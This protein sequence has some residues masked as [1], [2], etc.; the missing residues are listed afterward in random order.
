MTALPN[1]T[2]LIIGI[3]GVAMFQPMTLE[4]DIRVLVP[5]GFG[6]RV[7]GLDPSPTS[8]QLCRVARIC[9]EGSLGSTCSQYAHRETKSSSTPKPHSRQVCGFPRNFVPPGRSRVLSLLESCGKDSCSSI[10]VQEMYL[11]W[12][13]ARSQRAVDLN[14][15]LFLARRANQIQQPTS[16]ALRESA[17]KQSI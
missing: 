5:E 15:R 11:V 2:A 6:F 4:V 1:Y 7:L 3:I 16:R 8:L 10:P 9:K 14:S 13:S 17:L 12:P